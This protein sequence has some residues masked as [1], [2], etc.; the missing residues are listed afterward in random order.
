LLWAIG[1]LPQELL[2]L[3]TEVAGP[4]IAPVR[5]FAYVMSFSG[6]AHKSITGSF[7]FFSQKVE[8]NVG[9]LNHHTNL[10][11]SPGVY[12]VMSGRFTPDQRKIIKKRC[13][14]EV[15]NFNKLY[16]WLKANNPNYDQMPDIST[17]PAPTILKMKQGLTTLM[18]QVILIWKNIWI[19]NIGFQGMVNPITQLQHFIHK[20]ILLMPFW[21]E[22][23]QP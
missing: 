20:K 7:T 18:P 3:I 16:N 15:G 12:V 6:G 22:R 13:L 21:K 1:T 23:S 8:E 4:L 2:E 5:P 10:T 9:A 19:S 14:V 17:C 11:G